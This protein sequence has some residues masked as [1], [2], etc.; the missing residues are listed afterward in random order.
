MKTLSPIPLL[1]IVKV[2]DWQNSNSKRE[3]LLAELQA[4]LDSK[5]GD[6]E[7]ALRHRL[8]LTQRIQHGLFATFLN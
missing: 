6:T 5:V 4:A 7:G 8:H 1:C 3:L 2:V